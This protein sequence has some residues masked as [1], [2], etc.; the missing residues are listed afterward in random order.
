MLWERRDPV[1]PGTTA[2]EVQR[3]PGAKHGRSE[4]AKRNQSVRLKPDLRQKSASSTMRYRALPDSR[5]AK[6]SLIPLIG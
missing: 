1:N 2:A 4:L 5:R 6:A 3:Y